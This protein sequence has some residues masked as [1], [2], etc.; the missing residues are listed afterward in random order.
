MT[1]VFTVIALIGLVV[2]VVGGVYALV[3][4]TPQRPNAARLWLIG[5]L[6]WAVAT[7]V[8]MLDVLF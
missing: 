8:L 7:I 3:G 2:F 1:L 5:L 4:P 6:I